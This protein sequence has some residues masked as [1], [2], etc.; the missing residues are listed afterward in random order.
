VKEWNGLLGADWSPDGKSLLV[1][2]HNF[3]QDSALLNVTLDGRVSIL[4]K[5]S[6]PEIWHAIP[7]PN[8]RM[9]AIAEAGGPK[10][11]WQI[12]NF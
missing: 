8:G 5:S 7:S 10:N 6:N 3:E 1:S 11:V 12:E 4:L 9:L 2:W